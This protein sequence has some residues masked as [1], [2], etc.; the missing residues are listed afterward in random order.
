MADRVFCVDFGSGFTK[1][2]L[3]RDPAATA[4]LV[5]DTDIE[6]ADFCFPSVVVIDRTGA[7]PVCEFG[8][9]AAGR[10]AAAGVEVHANWKKWLFLT[11]AADDPSA[12]PLEAFLRSDD[13]AALA[14]RHGLTPAHLTHLRQLVASARE[15]AAGLG[16]NVGGRDAQKQHFAAALA[17]NFF[18]WLR[19]EVLRA[20]ERLPHAGQRSRSTPVTRLP[21]TWR[22]SWAYSISCWPRPAAR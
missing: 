15:L 6:T 22:R 10:T 20:C 17:V 13:L 7:K 5:N 4:Q 2:G 3:R 1:V 14:A 9:K 19:A 12:N 11:P 8:A 18:T 21:K 16:V